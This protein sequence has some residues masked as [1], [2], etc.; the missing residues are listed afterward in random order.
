MAEPPG[1]DRDVLGTY[2]YVAVHFGALAVQAGAGPG[3]DVA[4]EAGPHVPAGDEADGGAC[5][6]VGHVVMMIK[7]LAAQQGGHQGSE[8]PRG[9]VAVQGE[10]ANLLGDDVQ[11]RFGDE[12]LYLWTDDLPDGHVCQVQ[13]GPVGDGCAAQGGLGRAWSGESVG[14]NIGRTWDVP[15]VSGVLGD[16]GQLSLLAARPRRRHPV[17]GGDE[18]LVIGPQLK[19]AAF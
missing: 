8:R 14:D 12:F 7:Y 5:A 18:G 17:Q 11:A 3:G 6:R 1:W 10:A 2:L 15:E 16:V 4:G 19:L 9:G 13:G